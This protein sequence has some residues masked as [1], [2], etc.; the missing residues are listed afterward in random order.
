MSPVFAISGEEPL[1]AILKPDHVV[2][3]ATLVKLP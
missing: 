2:D 1:I 3:G